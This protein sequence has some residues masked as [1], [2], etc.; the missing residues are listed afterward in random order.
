PSAWR[1]HKRDNHTARSHRHL[2]P[3]HTVG[4]FGVPVGRRR[5]K[6]WRSDQVNCPFALERLR[7]RTIPLAE[8]DRGERTARG[9]DI[10]NAPRGAVRRRTAAVDKRKCRNRS[11]SKSED[12][13]TG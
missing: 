7:R 12:I 6:T 1:T 9:R 13:A 8:G 10:R 11:A 5:S 4:E 3:P 2:Q